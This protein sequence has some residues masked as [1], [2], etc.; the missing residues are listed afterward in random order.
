MEY[1]DNKEL[2]SVI[3][4]I[5]NV[6]SYLPTC[7]KSILNQTYRNIEVI[8]VDDGSTDSSGHICD[9]FASDDSRVS[10]IHKQNGGLSDARNVGIENSKGNFVS[11]IDSDDV[12]CDSF[13]QSLYEIYLVTGSDLICC[14]LICFYD[15]DEKKLQRYW[16]QINEKECTY[17]KYTSKE[18]IEQSFYQHISI[19]GAPQKLYK[20]SLFD[21]IKFPRGRYFE[22]LAT[23]YLFFEKANSI[24]VIDKKLYAYRM[25]T[26]SIMNRAF[27]ANKLDCVWVT[28]KIV[29]YYAES[30]MDGVFCAAF[31]VNRLVYDQI[32]RSY[33]N[34]KN[35]V[36]NEIRKYRW[37]VLVDVKAQKYE[38]L[39]AALSFTGKYFFDFWLKIF[40]GFRKINYKNSL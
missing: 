14:E 1:T 5:Y 38:R 11:L 16:K 27:D 40:K 30:E 12:V 10:V 35:K 31:R 4:P 8:L 20:K 2:I 21:D 19:T 32:P 18:I 36:W 33:K 24:S 7:I 15:E 9:S 34:E 17:K 22:D 39:L 29:A 25:R 37:M 13:I 26:D 6:E 23:T 3:V 28:E